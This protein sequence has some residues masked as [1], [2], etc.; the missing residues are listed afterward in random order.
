MWPGEASAFTPWLALD[1]NMQMLSEALG[2]GPLGEC[3]TEEAIGDFR[4]DIISSAGD[5]T[6]LVENQFGRTDHDHLGKLL[7]YAS[8]AGANTVIWIAERFRDEHRSALDW[9]N[10]NTRDGLDFFGVRFE[11]WR[12]GSSLPA[13]KFDVVCQPNGWTKAVSAAVAGSTQNSDHLRFWRAFHE[14]VE[15]QAPDLTATLSPPAPR[16]WLG[17]RLSRANFFI[18]LTL[19]P[20]RGEVS[21]ELRVRVPAARAVFQALLADRTEIENVAGPLE[22]IEVDGQHV[23]RIVARTQLDPSDPVHWDE[24]FTWFI[25]RI[26]ALRQAVQPRMADLPWDVIADDVTEADEA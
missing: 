22:W 18:S 15:L 10:A 21:C 24:I 6:V 11:L 25:Q 14:R 20:S 8:G 1:E 13:P 26:N 7:V 16:S 2:L 17:S 19:I 9:L 4:A 12:I 23:R 5:G 3:T